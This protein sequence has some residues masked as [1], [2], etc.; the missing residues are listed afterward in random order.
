MRYG[1][2]ELEALVAL[3]KAAGRSEGIGEH[4]FI[5]GRMK[6]T[7]ELVEQMLGGYW[8]GPDGSRAEFVGVS[9][10]SDG[11]FYPEFERVEDVQRRITRYV[12]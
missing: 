7:V 8:I 12:G 1:R 6:V 11:M 3:R 9:V 10:D 2:D 5:E 4:A